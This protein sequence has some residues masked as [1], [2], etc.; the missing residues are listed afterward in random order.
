MTDKGESRIAIVGAGVSGILT[1]IELKKQGYKNVT[2]Y[3][4]ADKIT[5]LTHTFTHDNHNFDFSTK[6]IPSIGLTHDGIFPPLQELIDNTGVTLSTPP[7]PRFY[8]FI[9][10]KSMELPANMQRFKK[11]KVIS[12]FAK[13]FPLLEQISQC[14]SLADVNKTGIVLPGENVDAWATRHDIQAFG[15]FTN[16]IVDL[17][18]IGP[19][20]RVPADFV[21]MSRVHFIAPYLHAIL[22]KNL[23]RHYFKWFKSGTNDHFLKF[24]QFEKKRNQLLPAERRL[25]RVLPAPRLAL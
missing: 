24:I 18:N 7:V 4:K 20:Y 16:Y 9:N 2:L 12:D 11:N 17:F 15:A 6:L 13:A 14:N 21:L 25:Y 19:S 1:A 3:E 8:D 22:S 5:S 10:R 23:V